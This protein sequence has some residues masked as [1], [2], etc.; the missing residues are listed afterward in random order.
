MAAAL[1]TAF[2]NRFKK[3]S[4]TEE[5]SQKL[6]EILPIEDYKIT[7]IMGS[8]NR[9]HCIVECNIAHSSK[10]IADYNNR[11][12]RVY[13]KELPESNLKSSKAALQFTTQ[14]L[15]LPYLFILRNLL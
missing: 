8:V 12:P 5:L 2:R 1:L 10:F 7:S 15:Q 9:F 3:N 14:Q 4:T 11:I 6:R 13:T